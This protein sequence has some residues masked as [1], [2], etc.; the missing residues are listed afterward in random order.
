[1]KKLNFKDVR[2]QKI[3]CE[4]I[5]I[6]EG[7]HASKTVVLENYAINYF[8]YKMTFGDLFKKIDVCAKSLVSFGVRK[9]DVITVC[10]PNTPEAIIMI[11]AAN[12]IGAIVNLVHPLSSKEELK[13][14]IIDTNSVF[15]LVINFNYEKVKSFISET[16]LYKV[17]IVSAGESMPS[18]L[19]LGYWFSNDVKIN[20]TSD[21]LFTD[22]K[23]FLLKEKNYNKEIRDNGVRA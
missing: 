3:E 4:D 20:F 21:E 6:Y 19:S 15:A 12:K 11:Y 2:N 5:S 1:M 8:G 10:M 18:L 7:L 22:W 17:I 13:R 14:T 23:S 16:S 9:S